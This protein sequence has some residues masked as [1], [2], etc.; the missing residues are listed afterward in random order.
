MEGK[1]CIQHFLVMP[2]SLIKTE[3]DILCGLYL[4]TQSYYN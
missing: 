3:Y 1:N 4:Y 2:I